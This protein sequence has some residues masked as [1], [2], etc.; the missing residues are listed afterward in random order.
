M[1]GFVVSINGH[2]IYGY[3]RY[4]NF[5]RDI[6]SNSKDGDLFVEVGSFLGQSTASMG[7]FIKDSGKRIDFHAVDIFELSDFS[8]E[9]HY[10]VI[11]DHG[12]DF[13]GVFQD[14]LEKAQVRDYV[15]P[16]KATSLEAAAQYEDRSIDFLM[17]DA[18][19]AYADVVD[20]IE[21]WYPKI[22]LGGIISGD[23]YDFEEVAKAVV[24]TCGTA[25]LVYPNTTWWFRKQFL[26]ITDQKN[27]K[28]E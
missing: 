16:V 11:R 4:I 2:S 22:K 12:G 13:Y 18:S 20:D 5:Y 25:V 7:K 14:N 21:A 9:P 10:Q 26:D 8:D 28:V 17:I 3:S 15:N 6:V 19:H 1:S 27:F 23:D 24:D